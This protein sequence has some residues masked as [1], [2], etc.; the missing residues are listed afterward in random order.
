MHT[1]IGAIG[2]GTAFLFT[3]LA[4]TLWRLLAIHA[5]ASKGSTL[6]KVGRAMLFQY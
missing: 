6:P 5:I 4:G 3:V 2:L 1:H